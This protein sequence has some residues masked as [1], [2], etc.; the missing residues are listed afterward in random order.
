MRDVMIGDCRLIKHAN[1]YEIHPERL[2]G[3]IHPS[4]KEK[5]MHLSFT[6]VNVCSAVCVRMR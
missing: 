6:V 2:T 5:A 4:F 3:D 1:I